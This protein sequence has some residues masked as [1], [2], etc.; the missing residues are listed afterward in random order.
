MGLFRDVG[1]RV[2][3]FKQ[4]V[5]GVAKDEAEYE[6]AECGELVYTDREDCPE[7]GAMAVV[8]REQ[9]GG[10]PATEP[11]DGSEDPDERNHG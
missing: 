8:A 7:C 10:H 11:T 6:C 1:N 5:E 4:A 3:R 2:E 9:R